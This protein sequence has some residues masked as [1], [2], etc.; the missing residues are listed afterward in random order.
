MKGETMTSKVYYTMQNI[1]KCRYVL[2]Y[3]DGVKTHKDGSKFFDIHIFSNK[4][5]LQKFINNLKKNN[6]NEKG[7]QWL[8]LKF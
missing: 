4:K 3:H 1:G 5:Y 2:N 8:Y 6:Y 7:K